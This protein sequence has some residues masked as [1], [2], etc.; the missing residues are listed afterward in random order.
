MAAL[1]I[2]IFRGS[3]KLLRP[4]HAD[5]LSNLQARHGVG[6]GEGRGIQTAEAALRERGARIDKAA[7]QKLQIASAAG[8]GSKIAVAARCCFNEECG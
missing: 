8:Q 5:G 6:G 7:G 1:P 3:A 2:E 4:L